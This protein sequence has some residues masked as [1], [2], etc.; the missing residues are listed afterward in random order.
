MAEPSD[1]CPSRDD[2]DA[3]YASAVAEWQEWDRR[4]AEAQS[5]DIAIAAQR[6]L[7]AVRALE[8]RRGLE[9]G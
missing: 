9:R 7:E 1:D 8:R 4:A 6:S 5:C 2:L 3:A